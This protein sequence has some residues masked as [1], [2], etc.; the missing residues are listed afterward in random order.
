[1]SEEQNG[2]QCLKVCFGNRKDAKKKLK[3]LKMSK[4]H[5]GLTDVHYCDFCKA[6]H[7]TSMGKQKSRD[8]TRYLRKKKR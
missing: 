4:P 2:K 7:L 3:E 1:M 8:L 6:Y 5:L